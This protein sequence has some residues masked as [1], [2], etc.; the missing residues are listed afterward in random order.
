MREVQIVCSRILKKYIFPFTKDKKNYKKQ[1]DCSW[2]CFFIFKDIYYAYLNYKR[3]VNEKKGQN[4]FKRF[5]VQVYLF[6]TA[7]KHVIN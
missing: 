1:S 7:I 3:R 2:D 6:S 5:F 4:L